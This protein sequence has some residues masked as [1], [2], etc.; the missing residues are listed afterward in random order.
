VYA[1]GCPLFLILSNIVYSLASSSGQDYGYG[2]DLCYI[3]YPLMVFI[4]FTAPAF[5]MTV[6]NVILF[7]IVCCRIGRHQQLRSGN[8]QFSRGKVLVKL[9][10]LTGC[11]WLVGF[12]N[13][14][15][16]Q[17][18]LQYIF[19]ILNASQGIF[20]MISFVC[21]K[22]VVRMLKKRRK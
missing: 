16:K 8:S 12:V 22:R 2:L 3:S 17:D 15:I 1:F 18:A 9:S 13:Y 10:C 19:I 5:L 11:T 21:T 4:T 14:W 20:I 6:T 7:V